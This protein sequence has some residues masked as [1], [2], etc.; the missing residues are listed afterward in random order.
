M[1]HQ[2]R[3][4]DRA[5]GIPCRRRDK[6][7]IQPQALLKGA[8]QQW[9]L[10]QASSQA[11]GIDCVLLSESLHTRDHN[12]CENWLNAR[13]QRASLLVAPLLFLLRNPD[14]PVE[15]RR[16]HKVPVG[17]VAEIAA[18]DAGQ[19]VG[20]LPQHVMEN[21]PVLWL[22]FQAQPLGLVFVD[23]WSESQKP[24]HLRIEPGQ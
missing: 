1:M 3:S 2:Q 23:V 12:L 22:A 7:L 6:N 13:G 11:N 14:S 10:K 18:I 21:V 24:S 20:A 5:P 16:Q 8:D 9:I 17:L 4:A 15:F 19:P